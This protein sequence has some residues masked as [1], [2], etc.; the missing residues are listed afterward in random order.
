MATLK[1]KADACT[2]SPNSPNSI[3]AI[4]MHAIDRTGTPL[5][6]H[7][8]GLTHL[9]PQSAK[10]ITLDSI[11]RLASCTKLITSIAALRLV[12]QGK[13]S[14]DDAS[15]IEKHLP[16]LS[17]Q[18]VF[19]TPSGPE[20]TK[21]ANPITLRM[22]LTHSSGVGYDILSPALQG[23]RKSHASPPLALIGPVVD[24]FGVPLLFQP[25]EGWAYG[26]GLDWTGLLIERVSKMRFGEFLR[27]EVFDVVGCDAG[28]GFKGDIEALEREGLCVQT[29]TRGQGEGGG[30]KEWAVMPQKAELGGGGLFSS[31]RN[32]VKILADLIAPDPKLLGKEMLDLLFAPQLGE[33]SKPAA[34]LRQSVPVFS[35]M[36]GALTKGVR[37]E[38]INHGL[39]GLLV[40]E[41]EKKGTLVWGGSFNLLW[42]ANREKGVAGFYASSLFPPVDGISTGL[43][44][45]FVEEVWGRVGK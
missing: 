28:I 33:Q 16:E 3:L 19:T 29:V 40:T 15:I 5:V 39:G 9:N 2:A 38:G 13:L 11:F 12:Q 41:G 21:R 6:T 34:V 35:S 17:S 23:L 1:A 25:G 14:L 43:M 31:V 27:K 45:E 8:S 7:T 20:T 30:L 36:T 4:A 10:P 22:L 32:Y 42:F 44:E 24:A 26:G 18:G 37:P